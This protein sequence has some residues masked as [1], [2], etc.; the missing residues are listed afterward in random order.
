MSAVRYFGL[1]L[2]LCWGSN[3]LGYWNGNRLPT[4]TAC[5]T[6][7]S[8]IFILRP[9]LFVTGEVVSYNCGPASVT[10]VLHVGVIPYMA[11]ISLIF[12][13][14]LLF[15]SQ[16]IDLFHLHMHHKSVVVVQIFY[17]HILPPFPQAPEVKYGS[18][19]AKIAVH[20]KHTDQDSHRGPKL[21]KILG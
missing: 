14:I 17:G 3:S 10:W 18:R 15:Q 8:S 4:P 16:R 12:S 6:G 13:S 11:L 20:F 2:D 7:I 19:L 5:S 21:H 9:G 1:I